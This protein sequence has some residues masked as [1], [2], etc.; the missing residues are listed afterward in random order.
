MVT[1]LWL[2][3]PP[4]LF[5]ICSLSRSK[6]SSSHCQALTLSAICG[7]SAWSIWLKERAPRPLEKHEKAALKA[8]ARRAR[9]RLCAG[10]SP[11]CRHPD[12]A[13][14]QASSPRH[15]SPGWWDRGCNSALPTAH[16]ES[17]FA[18]QPGTDRSYLR[19]MRPEPG[20]TPAS[21]KVPGM[22]TQPLASP[23]TP[24]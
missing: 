13:V 7:K 1:S 11:L 16:C 14:P 3:E 23:S 15:L 9:T 19:P 10:V 12:A 22:D 17:R 18:S 6:R 20:S 2:P 8:N 4:A 21:Q 24:V 5:S